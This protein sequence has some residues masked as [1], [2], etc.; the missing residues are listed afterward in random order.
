MQYLETIFNIPLG[1]ADSKQRRQ[2]E[3]PERAN[4]ADRPF[5]Q[6]ANKFMSSALSHPGLRGSHPQ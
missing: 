1:R 4:K 2:S 3:R 6:R 5:Y